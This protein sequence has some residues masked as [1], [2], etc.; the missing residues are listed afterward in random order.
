M[1]RKLE[2]KAKQSGDT[3]AGGE[4]S[5]AVVWQWSEPQKD[6]EAEQGCRPVT[7]LDAYR[8]AGNDRSEATVTRW[9]LPSRTGAPGAE[10]VLIMVSSGFTARSQRGVSRGDTT[11]QALAA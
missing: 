8:Q 11:I 6:R 10:E 4:N 3:E 2:H 1:E 7:H 5:P 9:A